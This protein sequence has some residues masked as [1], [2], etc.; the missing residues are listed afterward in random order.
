[1]ATNESVGTRG[2]LQWAAPERRPGEQDEELLERRALPSRMG[3]IDHGRIVRT[4]TGSDLS[5]ADAQALLPSQDGD[6]MRIAV[7]VTGGILSSHFGHCEQ[8]V[9]FD[10][11]A[12]GMTIRDRQ[13]L[14]PPPHE[15][16]TFPRWLHEQGATVIIA[17]GMGSRAQSLFDE[18]GIRVLVG[19]SSSDPERLIGDFL[20]GRLETG[21]NT[22]D[23]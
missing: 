18:N 12:D 1:L 13:V 23:Q 22:C 2:A 8:F 3:R 17:G 5:P 6:S 10:V 20:A 21:A 7:P 11:E 19:T 9:L 16:A 14:V 15:P 4:L